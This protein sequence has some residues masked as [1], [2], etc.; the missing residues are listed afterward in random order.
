MAELNYSPGNS[1][2][3]HLMKRMP[4]RVDLTAMVD[5]AFLL[6]TFFMLATSLAKPRSMQVAMPT[7][8]PAEAVPLS[9]SMTVCLGRHNQVMYYRG[10][11]DNPL[12]GPF[13]TKSGEGIRKAIIEAKKQVLAATGKELIVLV[14]PD[15]N[16]LYANLV[17]ALDE[18]D[19]TGV[20]TYAIVNIA[21]KDIDL[22]KKQGIY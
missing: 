3:K 15:K 6:I 11:A 5:L 14:K 17:D 19:I 10:M 13:L 18:L 8:I 21:A 22:L 9:R 20:K 1:G 4:V 12:T 16:S 7:N 2:S